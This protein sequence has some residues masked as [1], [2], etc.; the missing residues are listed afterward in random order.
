VVGVY[1][2]GVN[3]GFVLAPNDFTSFVTI[4]FPGVVATRAIGINSCGDIVGTYGSIA[5]GTGR[6][7]LLM[8]DNAHCD[9]D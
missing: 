7:F 2:S 8:R 9:D 4:D 3:H 5:A 1:C 6:G